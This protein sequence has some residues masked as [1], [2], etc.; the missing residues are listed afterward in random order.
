MASLGSNKAERTKLKIAP[1]CKQGAGGRTRLVWQRGVGRSLILLRWLQAPELHL[2]LDNQI[3][4]AS[5]PEWE[6][7]QRM[8]MIIHFPFPPPLVHYPKPYA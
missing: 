5:V 2:A 3:L 7:V 1:L 6:S 8:L 4:P